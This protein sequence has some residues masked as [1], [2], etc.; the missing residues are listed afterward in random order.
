MANYNIPSDL[1]TSFTPDEVDRIRRAFAQFDRNHDGHVDTYELGLLLEQLGETVSAGTLTKMMSEVDLDKNSVIDFQEFARLMHGIYKGQDDTFLGNFIRRVSNLFSIQGAGGATHSFSEDEKV[2]FAEHIN[3]CL[4]H[5]PQ[6]SY[7]LPINTISLELFEKCSDGVILC[8]LVNLAEPDTVDERAINIKSKLNIYQ[9]TENCNLAINAA[10]GIG[11]QVTNIGSQD[12][13]EGRPILIL[14]LL[15][16][17]IRI[18]LLSNVTLTSVPELVCLLGEG[19]ELQSLLKLPP[20][21]ILMRWFNYHLQQAN[22]PRRVTNFGSDLQDSECYGVLLRRLNPSV[23]D[24]IT[25][26]DLFARAE[27]IIRNAQNLGVPSFIS[28]TDI[29]SG[30]KKLNL[31]FVAQIFNTCHG[32]TVSQEELNAYDFATLEIDDEGDTREERVF[33][34]WINSLDI[35][36]LYV[37]NLFLDLQDGVAILKIMDKVE[38]GIVSW[39]QVNMNPKNRYKKVENGNYVVVLGKQMKFVL[40][41]VGGLD[42]VDGN[43]KLILAIIWQLMRRHTLNILRSLSQTGHEVSEQEIVD[44]ANQTVASSGKISAIRNFHDPVIA[45]GYYLIDLCAAIEPRAVNWELVPTGDSDDD[46][47]N[48]AKYAISLARKIGACVFLTPDDIL[49]VKPKMVM[50]FVASLWATTLELQMRK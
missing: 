33:R 31:G 46:K 16:Q 35:D 6:L 27:H 32:L 47:K 28:S 41:N 30:N 17:I 19:E 26:T 48:R 15:W 4:G 38:P 50:P 36:G 18:Q 1:A 44:W 23:C 10:K 24:P 13:I 39:R 37:N 22:S 49:E 7:I 11:C 9:K 25:E 2:A 3:S 8:K 29:I 5:D 34:M 14:G 45:E 42:I 43:K 21:Q 12:I 40:V 20:E